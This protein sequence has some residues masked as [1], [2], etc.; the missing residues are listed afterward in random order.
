MPKNKNSS[1][2]A[3]DMPSELKDKFSELDSLL[4]DI[5]TNFQPLLQTSLIEMTEKLNALERAKMDLV[6]VYSLNSLFWM[7]LNISGINPKDHPIKQEMDRI[8][9]YMARVKEIQDKALAPK[10]DKPA[11]KRFVKSALWQAAVKGTQKND[12][13]K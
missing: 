10:L 7:Y 12:K 5:E 3:T 9:E 2:S 11:A 13:P 8:K 4:T 1:K 6:A